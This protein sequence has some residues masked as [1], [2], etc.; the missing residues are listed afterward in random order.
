[1]TRWYR[2][3]GADELY[4]EENPLGE[5]EM[6][7]QWLQDPRAKDIATRKLSLL[8]IVQ[9]TLGKSMAWQ[10]QCLLA[11][12]PLFQVVRVS[13]QQSVSRWRQPQQGQPDNRVGL[14]FNVQ[15]LL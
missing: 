2:L 5:I 11:S 6:S 15:S 9:R 13:H 1:M 14:L 3:L 7:V 4:D 8:E 12:H 10:Q